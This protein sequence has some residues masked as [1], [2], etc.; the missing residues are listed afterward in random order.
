LAVVVERRGQA[1][2]TCINQEEKAPF[3]EI[4]ALSPLSP[5]PLRILTARER[6]P[7]SIRLH[8]LQRES[9]LSKA[10]S[11]DHQGSTTLQEAAIQIRV[12]EPCYG[13]Q[14]VVQASIFI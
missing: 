3:Q 14:G 2:N 13:P 9:W 5:S 1:Q 4:K 11:T 8:K 10:R 12:I 7:L 6:A